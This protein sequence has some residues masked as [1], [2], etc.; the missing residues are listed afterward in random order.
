MNPHDYKIQAR[1]IA[2]R[3]KSAGI[4]QSEVGVAL[5]ISQSQASRLLS[6]NVKRY[7]KLFERLCIYASSRLHGVPHA[8]VQENTALIAALAEVWDGTPAHAIALATVI[9]SLSALSPLRANH[10]I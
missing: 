7:E 1:S 6:G 8:R 5:G 3:L 9:R 4:S 2:L 10:M